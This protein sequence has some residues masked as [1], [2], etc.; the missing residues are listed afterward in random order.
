M[1]TTI[2]MFD[3]DNDGAA[4]PRNAQAVAGYLRGGNFDQLVARFPKAHHFGISTS[5]A[6][7]GDCLDVEGG[8]A[9]PAQAAVWVE[10]RIR[11][12]QYRPCVYASI[13]TYMP[14][15]KASLAHLER[16]SYRLWVA[17]WTGVAHIEPGYDATQ[18]QCVGDSYDESLCA[19]TFLRRNHNLFCLR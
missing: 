10:E 5:A 9:S 1:T 2:S 11:A 18:W 7:A 17:H 3:C 12:G 15:V 6:V 19:R 16:S 4:I 13:D 8:D 14:E